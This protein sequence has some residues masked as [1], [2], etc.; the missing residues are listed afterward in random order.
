MT[1]KIVAISTAILLLLMII[2]SSLQATPWFK[3]SNPDWPDGTFHG[4]WSTKTSSGSIKGSLNQGR[5]NTIGIFSATWN[6]TT[7]TGSVTG[8]YL[9]PMISGHWIEGN[10]SHPFTGVFRSVN[11]SFSGLLLCQGL[12]MIKITGQDDASFMPALTGPYNIGVQSLHLIDTTRPENFTS[13]PNDTREIMVQLWYPT[14]STTA[15]D[16]V[17]YMD[18]LTFLWLK[19]QSPIPLFTIPDTAYEF[20]HPHGRTQ[21]PIAPGQHPVLIFSPGYDGVYQIY[22]SLIE[23]LA[24]HGFVVAAIN[25]PYVSGIV[26]FPGNRTVDIATPPSDPAE[27]DAFLAMSLRTMIGDAKFTLDVLTGMNTSDP[28]FAGHFDLSRVGMLGH[29][30]GGGNTGSCCF[31]DARFKAGLTLDG[32]FSPSFLNGTIHQPFCMM[33]Q[34]SR[35]LPVIDNNTMYVWNH[36]TN[37]TFIVG[38]YGSTHYA[39]TDVGVLL[40]HLV[41][42]IPPK[43]LNFG[44]ITPKRMVNITRAYEVTFFEV[45]LE[46]HPMQELLDL[47]ARYPEAMVTYKLG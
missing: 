39:Y 16:P 19:N 34:E 35:Y 43:A 26:V 10:S 13:D 9:G 27:H 40:S 31:E 15:G 8:L 46:G 20:V 44:T 28:V 41:P 7:T 17:Q 33:V 24:S 14:D 11:A 12:G 5:R 47:S 22:T 29:S 37:D 23:D 42:F 3:V 38:I 6:S 2:P 25:H 30:F 18:P 4:T 21:A 1:V 32:Y 45:Y 36:T